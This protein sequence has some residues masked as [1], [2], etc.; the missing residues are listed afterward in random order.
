MRYGFDIGGTKTAFG[1]F[2]ENAHLLETTRQATP[3]HSYAAFLE[4]ITSLVREADERLGVRG[5]VG[6]GF[7]G[8]LDAEGRI[9][10]PNVPAI[11]GRE[12]LA[13]LQARLKR[14]LSGDND[15]NCF[16]LSE[17]HGGAVAGSRLALGLTLGTGVGG[18]LIHDGRLMSSRR[19][20]SG[21]FGHGPIDA[22]L[23]ARHAGLPLFECG[24][25]RT[26]CL[27]AY[28]SGTGLAR[29]YRHCGG[30]ERDGQAIIAAWQRGEPAAARCMDIY[31]DVLAA[32]LGALMTQLDPDAVVLGGSLGEAAW[33]HEALARR[34]P[35]QM[36]RGVL[37]APVHR[38][39]F[40]G[41]GGMRGAALLAGRPD[42]P[43]SS[44]A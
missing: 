6:L 31:F 30:A 1:V 19:G 18:A 41:A 24:C 27:E 23:L 39:V 11:H 12:L 37:A 34:L 42:L 15:A 8:V 29:L 16:L 20:G 3:G 44:G 35:A 13:D 14:P 17:Y 38:P 36:M 25:G 26:A 40:G 2:D 10:A 7:P 22:G 21:E 43:F 33:L 5:R 28:V 4:L 32:G 9:L